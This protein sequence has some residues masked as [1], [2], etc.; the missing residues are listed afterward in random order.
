MNELRARE[1]ANAL[2]R[3]L[4]AWQVAAIG[5]LILAVVGNYILFG[6]YDRK[7]DE[8]Q[9]WEDAYNLS[10]E[11]ADRI[12]MEYGRLLLET[13]AEHNARTRA[14]KAFAD[15]GR[16]QYIG[17]C[18]LTAYCCEPYRHICGDGD[19]LTATG[20]PVAPGM[21]AVDPAVIPLGSTVVIDGVQ[22][23]AA[24]TGGAIDGLEVDIALATH[25][26]AEAFGVQEAEVWIIPE[27]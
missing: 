26:E 18:R 12:S 3:E 8:A 1:K 4:A 25:Q 19:G 10:S 14:A 27:Q 21:V 2:R 24:D 20:I 17:K 9:D 11:Y 15:A 6:L 16:Y 5:L 23:L 13:E 7:A 22:Y